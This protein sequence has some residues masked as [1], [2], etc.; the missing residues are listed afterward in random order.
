M[1]I[2]FTLVNHDNTVSAAAGTWYYEK[3]RWVTTSTAKTFN[4]TI[5]YHN[6]G[7]ADLP[8]DQRSAR[9]YDVAEYT[10]ERLDKV[11]AAR[12]FYR[13]TGW[14]MDSKC[15]KPFESWKAT[16]NATLDVY[17]GWEKITYII[18]YHVAGAGSDPQGMPTETTWY[19]GKDNISLNPLTSNNDSGNPLTFGGWYFDSGYTQSVTIDGNVLIDEEAIRSHAYE[20]RF[21]E[22]VIDVYAYFS[23]LNQDYEIT[24]D[25]ALGE[26]GYDI[27]FTAPT[28]LK[29]KIGG[30]LTA[31]MLPTD[32]ALTQYDTNPTQQYYFDGWLVN[33]KKVEAGTEILGSD[34]VDGKLT[35]TANWVKKVKLNVTLTAQGTAGS[36]GFFGIGASAGSPKTAKCTV[37]ID[38][39]QV[40]VPEVTC[41]GAEKGDTSRPA[42][43]TDSE[44]Y[45]LKPGQSYEITVSRGEGTLSDTA[46]GTAE[47]GKDINVTVTNI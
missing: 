1:P 22:Y 10:V 42:P 4:Y 19:D 43:V 18:E 23:D 15:E 46:S 33:G 30:T 36:A 7:G 25:L 27:S 45:Y 11:P 47:A 26:S 2:E 32:S 8:N 28:G 16:P 34:I 6:E 37:K 40:G 44:T 41:S 35:L 13:F 21:G 3:D 12:E 24:Y 29:I 38:G 39:N 20:N 9:Y 31:E 17:A 14:Y 5:Q